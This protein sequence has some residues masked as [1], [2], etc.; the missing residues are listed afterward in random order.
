MYHGCR[1]HKWSISWSYLF[2]CRFYYL[3]C[4][5]TIVFCRCW[6]ANWKTSMTL[7][8]IGHQLVFP[9]LHLRCERQTDNAQERCAVRGRRTTLRRDVLAMQFSA[10]MDFQTGTFCKF[11]S[12]PVMT[13][14][15]SS[16]C[17]SNKMCDHMYLIY[18]TSTIHTTVTIVLLII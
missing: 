13:I 10:I 3:Y 5:V 16:V 11:V 8:M 12:S 9:N 2:I 1:P 17:A 18:V 6:I 4:Y 14:D 15:L 7:L